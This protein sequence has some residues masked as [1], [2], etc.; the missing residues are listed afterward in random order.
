MY[1]SIPL[2]WILILLLFLYCFSTHFFL[3]LLSISGIYRHTKSSHSRDLKLACSLDSLRQ[4]ISMLTGC[5]VWIRVLRKADNRH[6]RDGTRLE[7]GGRSPGGREP[8]SQQSLECQF[9][10]HNAENTTRH[11]T[12]AAKRK[13]ECRT[14]FRLDWL[15]TSEPALRNWTIY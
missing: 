10:W 4:P 3:L 9:G 14:I 11:Q 2:C 13:D 15:L 12:L 5:L 7:A 8:G 6:S 1:I